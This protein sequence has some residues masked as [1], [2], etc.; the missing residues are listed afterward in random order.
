MV[1]KLYDIEIED[2]LELED[3]VFIDVRSPSEYKEDTIPGSINWPLLNDNERIDVGKIYKNDGQ[4]AAKRKA[5]QYVAL[6]MKDYIEFF[7]EFK[8]KKII[9]FCWRGG[10]R[11][12]NVF[13]LLKMVDVKVFRIRGGYKTY[14]SLVHKYLYKNTNFFKNLFVLDGLTGVGKTEIINSFTNKE[15]ISIDLE[16]LANNRGS[17]FGNVGLEGQPNQKKFDSLIF[18]KIYKK[19]FS[20]PIIIEGESKRIGRNFVPDLLWN[21]MSKGKRIYIYD[22]I[23][24][25]VT[26]IVKEYLLNNNFSINELEKA[27]KKLKS[28]LGKETINQLINNLYKGE[29]Y[30]VILFLLK[31]YYDKIYD[32]S[33]IDK[34]K[35]KIASTN[36][37][38]AYEEIIAHIQQVLKIS[39]NT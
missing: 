13:D 33:N 28:R 6:K 2:A 37:E 14:R 24:N 22:N 5:F 10:E 29:F 17:V 25:R 20:C 16:G 15:I 36:V 1:K 12:K 19:N 26:R 31:N 34:Y 27:I 9:I 23:D 3:T 30:K 11:S 4:T 39:R 21:S 38:K 7:Y 8:N 35:V 32:I 18:K